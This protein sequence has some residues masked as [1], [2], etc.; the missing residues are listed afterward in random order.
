LLDD[1]ELAA[2]AAEGDIDAFGGLFERYAREVYRLALSLGHRRPE[3]EDLMQDTFLAALEG[4]GRFEGRS[5][6]RTWIMAIVF[7]QSSRHRRYR[8]MRAMEPYDE[9]SSTMAIS[10]DA[11]PRHAQRLDVHAMLDSLSDEH[12]A[13]LV[14]R[15]LQGMSYDEMALTLQIPRGTVESR[16]FRARNLLRERYDEYQSVPRT[17]RDAAPGEPVESRHE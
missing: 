8:A 5:S 1:K 17:P 7:R 6:F 10:Q 11:G 14:L 13:V 16:L 4:I 9:A 12:R 15:E 3:A 2:Q